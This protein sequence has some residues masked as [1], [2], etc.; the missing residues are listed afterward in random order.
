MLRIDFNARWIDYLIVFLMV[1]MSAG[2]SFL[3]VTIFR[4]FLLMLAMGALYFRTGKLGINRKFFFLII[5]YLL[6]L[7]AVF[8]YF[9]INVFYSSQTLTYLSF[10]TLLL[11]AYYAV[12]VVNDFFRTYVKVI[13]HL[14][15]IGFVFYPIQLIDLD[16]LLKILRSFDP[17]Y[18]LFRD[19][20]VIRPSIVIFSYPADAGVT[21]R[22]SGF[23]TEPGEFSVFLIMALMIHTTLN[24]FKV[25]RTTVVLF[26]ATLTTMSTSGYIGLAIFF[27]YYFMNTFSTSGWFINFRFD[28]YILAL[29][30]AVLIG[31]SISVYLAI[32]LYVVYIAYIY[33]T[34]EVRFPVF[35]G[36]LGIPVV[37]LILNLDFVS[38]KITE[39]IEK[40]TG[41]YEQA[42]DRRITPGRFGSLMLDMKDFQKNPVIGYG[43]SIQTRYIN[44]GGVEQQRTNGVSDY[45]VKFGI[46]GFIIMLVNLY[47][48]FRL[49]GKHNKGSTLFLILALLAVTFS[50]MILATPFFLGLQ[51]YHLAQ[52]GKS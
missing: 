52:T 19:G 4:F 47:F 13:Y 28:K 3:G 12:M 38:D 30:I 41:R 46:I 37:V 14:C 9:E 51:Y 23:A 35:L 22:N 36:M 15:L 48:T 20:M 16:L 18:S 50:Q 44:Y 45:L 7:T 49:F 31:V 33:L 42:E 17:V 11:G 39:A 21:I 32:G 29:V 40:E 43:V 27:V 8:W 1:V 2:V 6:W 25:D 10:F 24:Q 34:K 26:I 5:F